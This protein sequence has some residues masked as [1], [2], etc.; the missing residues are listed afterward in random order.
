[1]PITDPQLPVRTTVPEFNRA[2]R[3]KKSL[4][5]SGISGADMALYLGISRE[6]VSRYCNNEHMRMP[7]GT[8]RLWAM[9]TGVP[10]EWILT[11]AT[12]A[13]FEYTS[14]RS[15]TNSQDSKRPLDQKVSNPTEQAPNGAGGGSGKRRRRRRR[16]G[17]AAAHSPHNA[18]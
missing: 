15:R 18:A 10:L 7:L 13:E 12:P 4:S 16:P 8:L 17:N 5:H 2:D 9:R 6:T 14:S 3:L 11:G 1:M